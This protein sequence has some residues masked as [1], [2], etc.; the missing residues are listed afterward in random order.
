MPLHDYHCDRCQ[1][2]LV[3]VYRSIEQG[4]RKVPVC[5]RCHGAMEWIPQIGRMDAGSGSSFTAFDVEVRQ[6]DGS[7]KAVH[8]DSLRKLRQVERD[9]EQQARNGEGQALRWRDY[10][11]D[12]SNKDVNTFGPDPAQLAREELATL[13]AEARS[14]GRVTA[15]KHR[16]APAVTLGA[17]VTEAT[18]S[19]LAVS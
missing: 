18:T 16:E 17:G 2:T 10:S 6:P 12:P 13:Q 11:Q 3:D 8:I 4:G 14:R 5:P 1:Y 9:T 7:H 19:P 15:E